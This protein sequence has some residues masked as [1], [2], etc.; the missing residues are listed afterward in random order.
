MDIK[1]MIA[2][3]QHYVDGGKVEF[4]INDRPD[5]EVSPALY[6]TWSWNKYTYHIKKEPELVPYNA[7]TFPKG[8]VWVRGVGWNDG[9]R[10]IVTSVNVGEVWVDGNNVF[11]YSDLLEG[12]RVSLDSGETWQVAGIV[13]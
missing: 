6:P 13:K 4:S 5:I 12:C 2:V 11:E 7:E 8:V 10:S 9:C 3:M 1:E